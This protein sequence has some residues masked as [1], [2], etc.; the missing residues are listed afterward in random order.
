MEQTEAILIRKRNWSDTSLIVTWFSAEHGKITTMARS[1][2]RP[3]HS[4]SGRLDLFYKADIGFVVSR[5]SSVHT[6]REIQ[7]LEV[8]DS[9][10]ATILFL[11]G[12][13]AEL[14]D[15]VTEPSDPLIEVYNL[16][17]RAVAHLKAQPATL[18]ALEFFE[19]E[20]CRLLGL[21]EES[22]CVLATIE[23]YCGSIPASRQAAMT[24]LKT[25]IRS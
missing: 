18:R 7:L 1:A 4:F 19:T 20:L 2:R 14:I 25:D 11:C 9:K 16:F 5:K 22:G 3:G 23:S 12:Y 6:L 15:M 17:A 24:L 8:F 21:H 10:M 13:F